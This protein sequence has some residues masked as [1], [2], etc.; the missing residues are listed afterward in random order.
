MNTIYFLRCHGPLRHQIHIPRP[1]LTVEPDNLMAIARA[2][3]HAV[4]VCNECGIVSSYSDDEIRDGRA[5]IQDPFLSGV[6]RLE[7]IQPSCDAEHCEAQ[8]IIHK[9]VDV[10]SGMLRSVGAAQLEKWKCDE[11]ARCSDG[12]R[13]KL[14][15]DLYELL[16]CSSPFSQ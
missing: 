7:C 2:G 4:F 3:R 1:N 5:P 12:H 10:A 13:L 6:Y 14:D 9:V 15:R 16:P 8:K 11:T